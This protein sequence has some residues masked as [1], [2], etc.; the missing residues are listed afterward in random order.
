M[1]PQ[2]RDGNYAQGLY[3]GASAV[4]GVI[5]KTADISADD[6][7]RAESAAE[8]G[9]SSSRAGIP[10]NVIIFI[11]IVIFSS[12]GRLGRARPQTRKH[13]AVVLSRLHDGL[14]PA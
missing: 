13:L 2:F 3:D 6:I 10:F 9:R 11:I 5:L 8:R 14:W 4:G 12:I 7:A 1:L